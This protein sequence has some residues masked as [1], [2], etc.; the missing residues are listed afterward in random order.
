MLQAHNHK[1]LSAQ[2]HD[3]K[4]QGKS[5]AFVPTMGNLHEGHLSL[6]RLGREQADK[7]VSSIF[8]NPMQFGPT[9]DLSKYPRTLEQDC[10]AL[11][12]HQ[13]DLVYLPTD[14]DLYPAGLEHM[15]AVQVPDITKFYEGEFRPGHLTGVSTIVLKLFNLVQP[16]VAVFGKK[17]YQQWR[18]IEKM[19]RDLNLPIDVIA[20]ETIREAD[21]LA[22]SSRNQYLSDSQRKL[23]S[24]LYQQ[25][26]QAADQL[27]NSDRSFDEI[28]ESAIQNLQQQGFEVDYF[29][30][31][32]RVN[33]SSQASKGSA[34]I[35]TAARLGNTRLIDNIEV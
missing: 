22:M 19:V 7:L 20:G 12:E 30:I 29:A 17:D 6:I 24:Q 9:E 21:S 11:M 5:I 8:V 34:V 14:S 26:I 18:M 10:K 16:N 4:R 28:T 33:L 32:D 1:E 3:W 35:L 13:C 25:L 15:T 23:A 2:I 31:R 27:R